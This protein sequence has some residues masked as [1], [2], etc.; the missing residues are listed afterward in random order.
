MLPASVARFRIWTEPTTGPPRPAP[1][2]APDPRVGDDRR[3]RRP[4][5]DRSDAVSV[6]R[7][8]GVQLGDALDVDDQARLE[9]PVTQPDDQVR[10]AGQSRVGAGS[11]SRAMASAR[12]VGRSYENGRIDQ[13]CGMDGD[14][15]RGLGR[16]R[17]DSASGPPPASAGPSRRGPRRSGPAR[18]A[19]VPS[20]S[21]ARSA[22]EDRR[23]ELSRPVEV[24]AGA[25][26]REV[27]PRER[28]ERR[29]H[30]G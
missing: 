9:R 21:R 12:L 23:V 19:T 25:D 11:A 10:A 15:R 13:R 22:V 26:E 2:I 28:L 20:V 6:S 3:H 30:A 16:R 5:A 1:G 4:C 18:A 29:P 24:G 7:M 8:L 27:R 17:G 14:G